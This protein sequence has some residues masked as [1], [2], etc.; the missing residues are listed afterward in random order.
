MKCCNFFNRLGN[1]IVKSKDMYKD[2]VSIFK[3]VCVGWSVVDIMEKVF[4]FWV[5]VL[6]GGKVFLGI[7]FYSILDDFI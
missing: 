2:W 7:Y 4:V 3:D 1:C 6:E 5:R